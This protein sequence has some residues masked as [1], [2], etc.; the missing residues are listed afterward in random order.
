MEKPILKVFENVDELLASL[1]G[2]IIKAANE[3]IEEKGDFTLGLSGGNSPKRL[4]E[5]LASNPYQYEVDWSRVHFFFGDERYVPS[6]NP[7]SNALM[8]KT[9]LFD[10]LSIPKSN[11]H[12]VDTSLSP[13]KAAQS[14]QT[15]LLSHFGN[16]PI[17]F[18]FILLGLG[19]NVHTASLFPYTGVLA[20]VQPAVKAV[21]IQE[22][23]AYRITFNAPLI[24][25]A[26]QV[27][28]LVYG[29][30]KAEAVGH[31]LGKEKNAE[32]YPAQ[33]IHPEHGL[34]YWFLDEKAFPLANS[35]S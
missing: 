27:A 18:D 32:K 31:A 4:Y 1:G 28:F 12:I 34:L 17:Q 25:Q 13:E 33:L 9:A 15:E 23:N 35:P 14:Y 29:E 19:D 3:A 26:S 16:R 20:D 24:N 21:F 7:E 8:V 22:L 5:L 30:N 11:I 10:P 2:F 6:N